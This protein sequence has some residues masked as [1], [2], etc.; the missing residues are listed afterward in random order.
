M[1]EP[2]DFQPLLSQEAPPEVERMGL[3]WLI[4]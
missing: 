3:T 4:G 1:K 2:N